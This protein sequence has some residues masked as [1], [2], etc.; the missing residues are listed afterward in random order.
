MSKFKFMYIISLL[1][2]PII[3]T[4]T[5]L[6]AKADFDPIKKQIEKFQV[7]LKENKKID[8]STLKENLEI[9]LEKAALIENEVA[10]TDINA[11]LGLLMNKYVTNNKKNGVKSSELSYWI[12]HLYDDIQMFKDMGIEG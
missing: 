8:K 1:L 12:K 5:A 7:I 11:D 6:S 4:F 3:L 10:S 9:L 2:I